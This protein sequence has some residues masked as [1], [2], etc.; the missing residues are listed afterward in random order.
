M[1]FIGRFAASEISYLMPP[2][3]AG[4]IGHHGLRK[5]TQIDGHD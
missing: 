4:R 5:F 2:S 1:T 3:P